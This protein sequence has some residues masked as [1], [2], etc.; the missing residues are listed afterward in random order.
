MVSILPSLVALFSGAKTLGWDT[1]KD[2]R[3]MDSKTL[4]RL[5]SPKCEFSQM[6]FEN[7]EVMIRSWWK[8]F[9]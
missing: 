8:G 9:M 7:E 5:A 6:S 3:K 1:Q 2:I 4:G